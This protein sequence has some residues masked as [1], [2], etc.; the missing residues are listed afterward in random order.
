MLSI[1]AEINLK[2]VDTLQKLNKEEI[3][4][5]IK[6]ASHMYYNS[7][8]P[9]FSD[10]VFDIV[11]DFMLQIN[12]SYNH[13]GISIDKKNT[14]TKLPMWL[15]SMNK[16]KADN[17][18]V[19][20]WSNTYQGPYLVSDKL[21]GLSCLLVSN[22][23]K[24]QLFTRGDGVYGQDISELI[25]Y[26][27]L[28]KFI[29]DGIMIRGEL[30]ISKD[31]F[32]MFSQDFNNE[33]NLVS[34][35]VNCKKCKT[36]AVNYIDYVCYQLVRD[37]EKLTPLEEIEQLD[38][39]G[40]K[41]V[42]HVKLFQVDNTILSDYLVKR[43]EESEYLIDGIVITNNLYY[44]LINIGN[45]KHSIAFKMVMKEQVAEATVTDV[46]WTPSKTGYLKPRVRIT[47]VQ[48]DVKI[49]YLTG[50]NG[51]FIY[52]N[53]IGIGTVIEIVHSGFVIPHINKVI[54]STQA[55]MPEENYH[56]NDTHVDIILD[57]I[58]NNQDVIIKQWDTFF[59]TLGTK[60][61]G[62]GIY[63]KFY[64]SGCKT[65]KDIFGLSIEKLKMINNIEDKMAAKIRLEL[66][67]AI[68]KMTL[69]NTM[70]GSGQFGRGIGQ[71][72]LED[73]MMNYPDILD[74][75]QSNGKEV[76]YE[77]I[78]KL[79]GFSDKTARQFVDNISNFID[80]KNNNKLE[81]V[82]DKKITNTSNEPQ[83]FLDKKIVFSG[84]RDKDL[85][86]FIKNK[87]G[88]IINNVSQ[89]T[90][91]LIVRDIN[92]KTSK[93]NEAEKKNI[94]IITLDDFNKDYR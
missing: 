43:R 41:V 85:E 51:A 72:K 35:V 62:L 28:P 30:V 53:N 55:K 76:V 66:D 50:F 74:M 21:D 90:F 83:I 87:G 73:I 54:K 2:P 42:S 36:E 12:P 71:S 31:S 1:I 52:N 86:T 49:E 82:E 26:L 19:Q 58:E 14:K 80:F 78:M 23:S 44:P 20:K 92:K 61:I 60:G 67:K 32:K 93:V 39:M 79:D 40:F 89:D 11:Y 63:K 9:V 75:Y 68:N 84:I 24:V 18:E 88:R 27:K 69:L 15:G 7:K 33:R 38:N 77:Q 45:P 56:W 16:T 65:I 46:I 47:P 48:L 10:E 64:N 3:D 25:P 91:M 81:I 6:Y 29:E 57:D 13:N 5:V 34:G 17:E 37:N 94:Q 8:D 4:N 59:R 22:N 70:I